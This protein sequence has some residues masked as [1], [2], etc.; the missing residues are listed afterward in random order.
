MTPILLK[1]RTYSG[2]KADERPVSF[3]FGDRTCAVVELIDQWLGA[4]HSYFKLR[5]DDGDV[6]ILRH[7]REDDAW[8]MVMLEAAG[9]PEKW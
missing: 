4:D 8:E 3:T 5:A 6:Y 2:Y 9:A 7:R 1:V